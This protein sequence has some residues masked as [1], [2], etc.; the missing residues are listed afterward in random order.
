MKD[1]VLTNKYAFERDV[2]QDFC[3]ASVQ[4]EEQ[5]ERFADTQTVSYSVL[6]DLIGEPLNKGLL[7]R[8]KDKA[9]HVFDDPDSTCPVSL[10]LDWTL[11]YIFHE[12]LKLMEDA[13]Q[14]QYY[15]PRLQELGYNAR[16]P[17]IAGM[18]T[19]FHLIREETCESMRRETQRLSTL[20]RHTRSLFRLYFTGCAMHR[21]L[22]RFLYDNDPL[23]RQAFGEEYHRLLPAVYGNLPEQMYLQAAES[24]LEGA[25]AQAAGQAVAAALLVNPASAEALAFKEAHGF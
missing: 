11:G 2:L 21:P 8:L 3:L 1:W 18:L 25:R 10:L 14:R 5:C 20:L 24:L 7:W 19:E 6:R 17:E 4:L 16:K 13:H 22:A 9:H 23:V 15:A 12:S